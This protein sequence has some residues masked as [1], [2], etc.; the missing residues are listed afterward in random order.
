MARGKQPKPQVVVKYQPYPTYP[1][2]RAKALKSKLSVRR[3]LVY[4]AYTRGVKGGARVWMGVYIALWLIRSY[5][6]KAGPQHLTTDKLKPGETMI[7]R[8][9]APPTR[10]QRKAARGH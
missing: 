7:I 9:I 3:V 6:K 4:N 2:P 1:F 5:R 8:T 10:A